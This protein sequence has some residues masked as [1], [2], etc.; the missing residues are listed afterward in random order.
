[1]RDINGEKEGA[2]DLY[3]GK[4]KMR[5]YWSKDLTFWRRGEKCR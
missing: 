5:P 3:E 1:M 2:K 4:E